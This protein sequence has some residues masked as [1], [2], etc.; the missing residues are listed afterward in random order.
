MQSSESLEW[1]RPTIF[2]TL[3]KDVRVEYTAKGRICGLLTLSEK[4]DL[5]NGD[6]GESGCGY[7]WDGDLPVIWK[8]K[9]GIGA[10]FS[11]TKPV[12]K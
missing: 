10:F 9:G 5:P 1:S 7:V 12:Q 4:C 2:R 3:D 6:E 8:C 11:H